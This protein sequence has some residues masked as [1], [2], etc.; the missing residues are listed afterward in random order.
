MNAWAHNL[1]K[2]SAEQLFLLRVAG[3]VERGRALEHLHQAF[4]LFPSIDLCRFIATEWLA[5]EEL[6]P[7]RMVLE[8]CLAS[9]PDDPGLL[10]D[11]AEV[12][13]MQGD[14]RG[15]LALLHRSRE[16]ARNQLLAEKRS[17]ARAA[18]L[19]RNWAR[20]SALRTHRRGRRRTRCWPPSCAGPGRHSPHHGRDAGGSSA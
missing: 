8:E 10:Q 18:D 15:R 6:A 19:L 12:I 16:S 9:F 5:L 13:A 2:E 3:G 11:L 7:A 20:A 4:R 1:K 17:D 14:S